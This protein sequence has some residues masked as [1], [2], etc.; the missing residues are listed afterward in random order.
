M[1]RVAGHGEGEGGKVQMTRASIRTSARAA[2]Q[3]LQRAQGRRRGRER[4][5]GQSGRGWGDASPGA[6]VGSAPL[7]A[8]VQ[9]ATK[10]Q[11][12][13]CASFP[14]PEHHHDI[15]RAMVRRHARRRECTPTDTPQSSSPVQS[16]R[17]R[18]RSPSN[19][20]LGAGPSHASSDAGTPA[21]LA[22]STPGGLSARSTSPP[23][24]SL[25]PSSPPAAFSDMTDGEEEAVVDD[26]HDAERLGQAYE[27]DEDVE[28]EDLFAEG[29][30]G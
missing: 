7:Y 24:S 15:A 10:Q 27:E 25:P 20:H 9:D 2:T 1:D 19:V 5:V 30:E 6:H 8:R 11:A 13:L 18:R 28:G 16:S 14:L 3:K 22:A 21:A 23:P 17:K 4:E 26:E 29:M 12:R